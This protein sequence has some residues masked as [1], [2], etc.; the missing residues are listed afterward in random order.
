[1]YKLAP[2]IQPEDLRKYGFRPARELPEFDRWC[3]NDYWYDNYWMIAM[4]PDHIGKPNYIEDDEDI[5]V[6]DIHIMPIDSK[7]NS[8]H[9]WFDMAPSCTYH[10]DNHDCEPAFFTL[11]EMIRDGV[12]VD[13]WDGV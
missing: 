6:W 11:F 9:I 7:Y 4:D 3:D 1:M 13:D 8:W 12:I 2:G 5:L 10:I